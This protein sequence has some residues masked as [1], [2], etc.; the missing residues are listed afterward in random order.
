MAPPPVEQGVQTWQ[1][2]SW[3]RFYELVATQFSNQPAY[4]FRG[5]ENAAWPIKAS[6]DRLEE[7]YPTRPNFVGDIPKHFNCPPAPRDVHLLAFR[8]SM[9]GRPGVIAPPRD[10]DECWALAQHHGLATP[11]LDWTLSPFVA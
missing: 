10:D 8:Q 1:L 6:L 9:R 3:T 7:R 11:M 5:H 4:I 2:D